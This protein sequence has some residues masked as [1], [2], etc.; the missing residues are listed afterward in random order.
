[1]STTAQT[2]R[3]VLLVLYRSTDGLQW[4]ERDGWNTRAHLSRWHGVTVND[5]G[6]VVQLSLGAN[7]LR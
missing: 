6:R 4:I 2:D 3:E 7:N 1:L 5:Q